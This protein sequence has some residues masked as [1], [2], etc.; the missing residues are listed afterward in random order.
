LAD[1]V[2]SVWIHRISSS[3]APYPHRNVPNGSVEVLCRVGSV[4]QIIGRLS[5]PTIE[6]LPPGS[7]V[8]GVRFRPGAAAGVFGLPA[9]ELVDITLDA[10]ELWGRSAVAVGDHVA[11]SASPE[12]AV[13]HLQKLIAGR[14]TGASCPDPLVAEAVRR[15]MHWRTGEVGSLPSLLGV[16]ERQ[17]RRRCQSAIGVAPKA[18]H[19]MLRFQRFLARAQFAL[20]RGRRPAGDGLALLAADAGYADQ[21]HLTR[22]CVRLTGL[23][24]R[25]FLGETEQSCG[26][27]HDHEVSFAPMLGSR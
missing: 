10:D 23:T 14:V 26:C 3:A 5:R 19:A 27:G 18:L 17:F 24:P 15:L 6:V 11:G 1:V 22:E 13:A 2:S 9:S 25:A 16:S 21:S 20:S 8:V 4:P 7:T 12:E